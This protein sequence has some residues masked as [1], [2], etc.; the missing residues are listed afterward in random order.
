[1]NA[2]PTGHTDDR[3][4]DR[5]AMLLLSAV[6]AGAAV[7]L[8]PEQRLRSL[9]PALTASLPDSSF[10]V[11]HALRG[12]V[13][14][15]VLVLF[16]SYL[17]PSFASFLRS[18]SI[19]GSL[20]AVLRR[21]AAAFAVTALLV[22]PT[23]LGIMG[24]GYAL[25]SIDPFAS[26]DGSDQLYQRIVMPAAAYFLQFK[27]PLL[28]HLFSLL[29]TFGGFVLMGLFFA[30]RGTT[31]SVAETLSFAGTALFITQFQSPGYSDPLLVVLMLLTVT[32]PLGSAGRLAA[33]ALALFTHESSVLVFGMMALLYFSRRERRVYFIMLA[34]YVVL[35]MVSYGFDASALL[36]ARNVGERSA[37][38]WVAGEPL[39]AV[40]GL[41]VSFKALWLLLGV[42][43]V[44][45]GGKDLLPML[46]PGVAACL[47][48]VDTSRLMVLGFL[49]FLMAVDYVKRYGLLPQQALRA[50]V[51][52]NIVLPSV[53]VAVNSGPVWFSGLY[54]LLYTGTLLR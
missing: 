3:F 50:V 53:Y 54:S 18:A 35:W 15:A 37:L 22:F 17:V 46:L 32:V 47:A 4:R 33:A 26:I 52:S 41:L 44:R 51:W 9:L 43:A 36:A 5:D 13:F 40:A 45:F 25:M 2:L 49:P 10:S 1:M 31:L 20:P 7:A 27:G 8:F 21:S 11:I 16:V 12:G 48:G 24:S 14:L 30:V 38:Q 34:V 23:T 29:L 19:R 39:L 6:A 28:F 42:A